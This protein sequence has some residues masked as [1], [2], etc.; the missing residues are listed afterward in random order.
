MVGEDETGRLLKGAALDTVLQTARIYKNLLKEGGVDAFKKSMVGGRNVVKTVASNP[1]HQLESIG[2]IAKSQIHE[3]FEILRELGIKISI[4]HGVDDKLFS[5]DEVQKH[6][7]S[8]TAD[9]FYSVQGTHYEI[10][11]HP[12]KFTKVINQALDALEAL[13]LKEKPIEVLEGE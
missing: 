1:R 4:I 13:R 12:E 11:L 2:V 9:G 6:T 7:T 10:Y 8:K 3:I 5:M